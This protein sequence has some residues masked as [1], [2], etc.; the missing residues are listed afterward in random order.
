MLGQQF[1]AVEGGA[2]EVFWLDHALRISD[3][4]KEG[5]G[6]VVAHK[7]IEAFKSLLQKLDPDT[8]HV[9]RVQLGDPGLYAKRGFG[10]RNYVTPLD[11]AYDNPK[12]AGLPADALLPAHDID[13]AYAREAALLRWLVRD[14]FPAHPGS[15]FL[16]IARLRQMAGPG[17]GFTVGGPAVRAAVAE[18][19]RVWREQGAPPPSYLTVEGRDLSLADLFGVLAEALDARARI[20]FI[21]ELLTV[22]PALGPFEI[23]DGGVHAGRRV[24][25]GAVA[26][27]ASALLPRLADDTPRAVPANVIPSKVTVSQVTVTA[28]QFLRLMAEALL[29]GTPETELTITPVSSVSPLATSLPR[30]RAISES[31]NA[32]TLKPARLRPRTAS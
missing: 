31:G 17:H 23:G 22:R 6:P 21:P 8:P 26:L 5:T 1:A 10:R 13:A 30:T 11:H 9:V 32:W 25:V 12:D 18:F 29:A 24:A 28:A 14:F 15:G 16:S 20:G 27:S 4:T 19:V 7:G 2:P 3:L